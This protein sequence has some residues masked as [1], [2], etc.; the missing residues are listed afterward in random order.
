MDNSVVIKQLVNIPT[1]KKCTKCFKFKPLSDF[2]V[3]KQRTNQWY[4]HCKKCELKRLNNYRAA[5]REKVNKQARLSRLA[6]L[7]KYRKRELSYRTTDPEKYK[8]R[9]RTCR[10]RNPK[11]FMLSSARHRAK[12]KNLGFNLK[13]SD[14]VIPDNCPVCNVKL[15]IAQGQKAF[16]SPS[17][18]RIIPKFGY[19][20]NNVIVI[21]SRC[22]DIKS[23]ATPHELL[24]I[25]KFYLK[26]INS[27]GVE[28]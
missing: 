9:R 5:N 7:E 2:H 8:N 17:L 15:I 21:C 20:I 28:S 4:S 24:R 6:N 11:A 13:K 22:N 16:Y 14:I 10:I 25:G 26:L 19:I 1:E 12:A 18:D 3:R 27:L 23:D